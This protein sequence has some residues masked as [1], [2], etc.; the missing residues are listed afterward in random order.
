VSSPRTSTRGGS[1][2][3]ARLRERIWR[4]GP[5]YATRIGARRRARDVN[6]AFGEARRFSPRPS[7][8]LPTTPLLFR[9][10]SDESRSVRRT[11]WL[12]SRPLTQLL[13]AP[14]FLRA[15]RLHLTHMASPAWHY[16]F[17]FII[18]GTHNAHAF[19]IF[20]LTVT[21]QAMPPLA[22]PHFWSVSRTSAFSRIQ[23]PPYVLY[24]TR[25]ALKT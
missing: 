14:L 2:P 24:L 15:P 17:K 18:T 4:A 22:S 10:D 8:L 19:F 6:A 3:R 20:F 9:N 5:E 1:V 25:Y 7:P 12:W 11:L 23:T 13:L 21:M 16:V